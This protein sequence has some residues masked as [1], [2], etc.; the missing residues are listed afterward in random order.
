[1]FECTGVFEL[2]SD[3]VDQ[4]FV[5]LSAAVAFVETLPACT[6]GMGTNFQRGVV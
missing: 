4:L 5:S 1:M 6:D 2:V 3:A